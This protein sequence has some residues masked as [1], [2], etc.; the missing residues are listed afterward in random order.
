M[1]TSQTRHRHIHGHSHRQRERE[2]GCGW[3]W[4]EGER[5]K[6][7]AEEEEI[8][9]PRHLSYLTRTS[10]FTSRT[11]RFGTVT[12]GSRIYELTKIYNTNRSHNTL[13]RYICIP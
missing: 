10:P 5:K 4:K 11:H 2:R 13:A 7:R 12:V 8:Q 9:I 1:L 6:E 3:G